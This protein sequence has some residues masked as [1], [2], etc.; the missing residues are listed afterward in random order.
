MAKMTLLEMTQ[1]I[2]S[3]MDSDE[4]NTIS[5]TV[6]SLQ[7]ATTIVET[8]YELYANRVNPSHEGLIKLEG[9]ADI[10]K[11]NYLRMPD[12]VKSVK[13]IRYNGIKVPYV[14]P[15]T[16]LENAYAKTDQTLITDPEFSANYYIYTD[17]E[18]TYWTTFDNKHIIFNGYDAS[19]E[20]TMHHNKTTCWGQR[21]PVFDLTDGSY[22][23]YLEGSDYPGLL[24]EAK[25]TC[26]IY[27]KQVSNSKEEQKAKRQR[28][29]AQNDSWRLDQRRPYDKLPDYGRRR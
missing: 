15:E 25:S 11:P 29:R 21:D 16:F 8:Y 23:P 18:P 12:N 14:D 9:L 26:F 20:S 7:V 10:T 5:D 2:L 27:F 4:V 24:A 22:A 17:G 3:S 28:V 13:W 6:E 1:N 19:V